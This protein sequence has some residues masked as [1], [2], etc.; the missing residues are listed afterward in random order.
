MPSGGFGYCAGGFAAIGFQAPGGVFLLSST[1]G[2][3]AASGIF[4]QGHK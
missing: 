4:I 2:M 3:A 1:G